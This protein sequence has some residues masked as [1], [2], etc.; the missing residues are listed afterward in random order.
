MSLDI[1]GIAERL[2]QF[3]K[4]PCPFSGRYHSRASRGMVRSASSGRSLLVPARALPSTEA[5]ATLR[6]DDANVGSARPY[7]RLNDCDRP[8]FLCIKKPRS[9]AGRCS[10]L[11][12]Q[13]HR[14]SATGGPTNRSGTPNWVG[15]ENIITGS[16]CGFDTF[17]R[18]NYNVE[19]EIVRAKFRAMAEG[20]LASQQLSI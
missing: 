1:N 8:G 10:G 9:V 6:C 18:S 4:E 13:L 16:D 19:S 17:A 14:A 5:I 11:H 15:R 7:G 20:A 12:D 3:L 2:E